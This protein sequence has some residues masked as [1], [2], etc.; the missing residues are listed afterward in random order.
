M[1]NIEKQHSLYLI[2]GFGESYI[3]MTGNVRDRFYKHQRLIIAGSN[4]PVHAFIR[5]HGGWGSFVKKILCTVNCTRAVALQMESMAIQLYNPTLNRCK[6]STTVS[7]PVDKDEFKAQQLSTKTPEQMR[8]YK[9]QYNARWRN[10]KCYG[11]NCSS[12]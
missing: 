8:E 12:S 11:G 2:A 6:G 5:E 4:I 9:R 3:G 1:A 7:V 10:N